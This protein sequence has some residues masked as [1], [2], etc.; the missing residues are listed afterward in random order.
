MTVGI[1]RKKDEP[2][3]RLGVQVGGLRAVPRKETRWEV[4][5]RD[6]GAPDIKLDGWTFLNPRMM[7]RI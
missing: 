1:A 3:E 4:C 6:F 5:M 7:S 2:V